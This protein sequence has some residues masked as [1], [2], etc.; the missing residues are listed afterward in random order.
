MFIVVL[1]TTVELGK[2]PRCPT[3]DKWIEKLWS[4]YTMGYYSAVK[5]KEILPFATSWIDLESSILSEINQ[6]EKNKTI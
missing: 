4:I 3:A 1:F 5:K 6:S 2:Q